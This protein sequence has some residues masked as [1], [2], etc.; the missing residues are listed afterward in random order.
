MT[1]TAF[2]AVRSTTRA[3]L[4]VYNIGVTGTK[5]GA[6][7]DQIA[8]A[9]WIVGS[10]IEKYGRIRLCQGCCVG[11]DEEISVAVKERWPGDVTV[12]AH[13]PLKTDLLSA[14]ALEI[15]DVVMTADNYLARDRDIVRH[16]GDLMI[17]APYGFKVRTRGSGT[18]YTIDFAVDRGRS[19]V[20]VYRDGTTRPGWAA[21]G[22]VGNGERTRG[23]RRARH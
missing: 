20:V 14:K 13:P 2:R 22:K 4:T 19:T 18:W 1:T 3:T 6:T 9:L 8:K 11:F 12:C 5:E 10:R 15:A 23:S 17:G 21:V 7:P 16:A